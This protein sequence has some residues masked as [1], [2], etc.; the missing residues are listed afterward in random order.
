MYFRKH[1]PNR[2]QTNGGMKYKLSYEELA[3]VY[4]LKEAHG[5]GSGE[6]S[7]QQQLSGGT[8]RLRSNLSL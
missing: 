4:G 7:L 6:E 2:K 5:G 1:G 8:L 3:I